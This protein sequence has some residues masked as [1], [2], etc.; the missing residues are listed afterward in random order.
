MTLLI[1]I[2]I[3]VTLTM[4]TSMESG[5]IITIMNQNPRLTIHGD[6]WY[7]AHWDQV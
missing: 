4:M 1:G 5:I 2:I 7:Q 6:D 3:M